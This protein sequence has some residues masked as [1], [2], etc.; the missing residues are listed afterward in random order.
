M[1]SE[2]R[3]GPLPPSRSS[4]GVVV[5]VSAGENVPTVFRD[6]RAQLEPL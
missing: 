5:Q 3:K 2:L 6:S 1:L 4:A